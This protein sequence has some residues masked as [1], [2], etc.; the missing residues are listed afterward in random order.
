V[1]H[2]IELGAIET[3]QAR[4]PQ[5]YGAAPPLFGWWDAPAA[6]GIGA[7]F[8]HTPPYPVLLSGAP[9]A[10]VPLARELAGRGRDLPGINGAAGGVTSFAAAWERLSGASSSVRRRSR[11]F[12][13]GGLTG[14]V[15][16]P[17]GAARVAGPDDTDLLTKWFEAFAEEAGQREGD[18]RQLVEDRLSYGGLAIWETGGIPVAM[19]GHNRPAAGVI[20][21]GPVYTPPEH[22]RRGYGGAATVAVSQAALDAGAEVVLFT[23]LANPTSNAL[24]VRLGYRPVADR[25]L[26]TFSP[27]TGS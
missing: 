25:L 13:L 22:R 20:R 11:L 17:P 16:A 19:A 23:D 18:S 15:P 8:F 5:A 24:Y 4:G 6:G 1:E 21:V 9:A 3:L 10:A 12:R 2:T 7:A 27:A 26:L 14:A